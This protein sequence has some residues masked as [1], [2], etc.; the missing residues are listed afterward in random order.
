MKIFLLLF[1]LSSL[2]ANLQTRSKVLMG[3]FATI[4]LPSS[5]K[6]LFKGSFEIGARVD[7]ALS[8]YKKTSPIYILNRDKKADINL[9]TYEAL[10][11]AKRYY[12]ESGGY[13]NIAVG[14]VTKDLYHFGEEERLP[15]SW[16]LNASDTSIDTLYFT[17]LRAS[18]GHG[19]KVDLGGFGK[20][21]GVDRMMEYL[22]INGAQKAQV[23]FSGDIRCLGKCQIDI[24]NPFSNE[25]LASFTT[26][27]EEMGISTSGNYNRF[28]STPK[29][30]HLINPKTKK[31]QENFISIT[32][33]S[34]LPNSDIDA[35][36][37]AASV[38]PKELA[39]KFLNSLNAGYIILEEDGKL[40]VSENIGLFIGIEN[41]QE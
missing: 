32:L 11:L 14:S 8:S 27:E 33:I 10:V 5:N 26:T 36:A 13:F 39:Y 40:V 21:Y 25:P 24:N 4:K 38:M 22:K 28:V 30:N 16:E 37:T 41:S 3:T 1:L 17:Q 7:D 20:G 18:I 15:K 31:S 35:Y 34:T 9:Y 29:N 6:E 23:A 19:V 12:K 2:H